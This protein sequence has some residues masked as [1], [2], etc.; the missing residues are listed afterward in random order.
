MRGGAIKV[1]AR[2]LSLVER[3]GRFHATKSISSR[4]KALMQSRTRVG[5]GPLASCHWLPVTFFS[6][7]LVVVFPFA[8]SLSPLL[9]PVADLQEYKLVA[10]K[11]V[12]I[13]P[14]HSRFFLL[15]PGGPSD[16]QDWGKR[17]IIPH[18]EG[19]ARSERVLIALLPGVVQEMQEKSYKNRTRSGGIANSLAALADD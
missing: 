6:Q 18:R 5:R 10:R 9:D 17:T 19:G 13:I 12:K 16:G 14:C 11:R 1:R 8:A 15:L 7:S 4:P 3:S 2:L